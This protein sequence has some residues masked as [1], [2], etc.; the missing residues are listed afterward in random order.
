LLEAPKETGNKCL[1]KLTG[2][3]AKLKCSEQSVIDHAMKLLNAILSVCDSIVDS[4]PPL[5]GS[6]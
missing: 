2:K 3:S 5:N 1:I 6:R 4:I